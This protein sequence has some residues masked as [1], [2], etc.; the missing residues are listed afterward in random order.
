ME[1]NALGITLDSYLLNIQYYYLKPS[2]EFE[3][4]TIEIILVSLCEILSKNYPI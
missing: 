4:E 2:S 3:N 1:I